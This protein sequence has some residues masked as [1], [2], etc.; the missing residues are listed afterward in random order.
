MRTYVEI[1]LAY[2]TAAEKYGFKLEKVR[3]Q[4]VE[5]ISSVLQK[6]IDKQKYEAI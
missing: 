3:Y 5:L 4:Y 1:H 2:S 6:Q